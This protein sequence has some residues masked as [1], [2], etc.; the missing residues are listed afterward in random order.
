MKRI[1]KAATSINFA[2]VLLVAAVLLWSGNFIAGRAMGDNVSAVGL[3]F[4]RWSLALVILLPLALPELRRFRAEITG[5]WLYLVLLGLTG[6]AA[7]H[8][9]VYKALE[10]TTATNALLVLSI[11]PAVIMLLS[12]LTLGEGLQPYHGVGAA[13]VAAGIVLT[14]FRSSRDSAMR[15][16]RV[17]VAGRAAD[18][19]V[20]DERSGAKKQPVGT[21]LHVGNG[22]PGTPDVGRERVVR[23][24]KPRIAAMQRN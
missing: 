9:F 22:D 4:W 19:S 24:A 18:A 1:S 21:A 15:I 7:F 5:S 11:S 17:G 10:Y 14:Q 8:I 12:R 16:G 2:P 23:T 13:L 20:V 3:N 6:V